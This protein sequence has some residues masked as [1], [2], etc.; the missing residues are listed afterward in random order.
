EPHK[1]QQSILRGV[2]GAFLWKIESESTSWCSS[3]TVDVILFEP[4]DFVGDVQ[5]FDSCSGAGRYQRKE[6]YFSGVY[7]RSF[8]FFREDGIF[9]GRNFT[10]RALRRNLRTREVYLTGHYTFEPL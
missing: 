9:G 3:V 10:D 5:Q 6:I 1:S 7:F 8:I 2:P 4:A